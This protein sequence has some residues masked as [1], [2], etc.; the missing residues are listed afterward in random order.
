MVVP[1]LSKGGYKAD[2]GTEEG[3]E[4]VPDLIPSYGIPILP[5]LGSR[6][7]F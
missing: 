7:L 1:Q 4:L 5:K 3:I 2:C 6:L